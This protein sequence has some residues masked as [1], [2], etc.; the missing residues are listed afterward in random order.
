METDALTNTSKPK[1]ALPSLKESTFFKPTLIIPEI[2]QRN[3]K[4]WCM[5]SYNTEWSGTL[6]YKVS[7]SF[8]DKSLIL[9]CVDFFVSDVGT[10]TYT[11]FEETPDL[12]EYMANNPELL[13]L[14]M[15]LIHSHNNMATFFSGTDLQTLQEEGATR[16]HF[17]SLIVNNEGTYTARI[18][19]KISERI[20]GNVKTSYMSW[21]DKKVSVPDTSLETEKTYIEYF[22]CDIIMPESSKID[23]QIKERYKQLKDA[24]PTNKV[25][26]VWNKEDED[27]YYGSFY[28][29]PYEP[30]LFPTNKV[31]DKTIIEKSHKTL[32]KSSAK[33]SPIVTSN[34]KAGIIPESALREAAYQLVTGS[35]ASTGK[36]SKSPSL[37]DWVEKYMTSI[38]SKRFDTLEEYK[39]WVT[40]YTEFI[41]SSLAIK[42]LQDAEEDKSTIYEAAEQLSYYMSNLPFNEYLEVI[43]DELETYMC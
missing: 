15:A 17:L 27:T 37:E 21:E 23:T 11:E 32:P 20:L 36:G 25:P 6:W 42:Y 14:P 39:D 28:K 24:K 7:G 43:L 22:E 29:K 9:T 16:N 3:I 8:E 30:T 2:V 4:A 40:I 31:E 26:S 5:N 13:D 34:S 10:S 18:T 35:I 12:I 1:V 38:F 33:T 41:C 19:R